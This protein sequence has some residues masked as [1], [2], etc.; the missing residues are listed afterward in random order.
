MKL[1]QKLLVAGTAIGVLSPIA[2]QASET[3][4]LEDMK[5]YERSGSKAKRFDSN[6]FINEVS[7]DI[8]KLKGRVDGLEAKQNELEA[9]SFSDTTTLDG[10]AIFSVGQADTD[11]DGFTGKIQAAYT[12]TMNLNTSFTGDD[13]LY[14]RLKTGENAPQW[15]F[16]ETYH[17]D[18]KDNSDALKV[19]KIWYCLLYTSPS[20]RDAHESRMP[21]SA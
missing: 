4:N 14:V 3:F 21:S 7:E 18:T 6:T 13:N 1:F 5:S 19:D 2:V 17:I 16:K 8:V 11:D 9:G 12:Y 20:P 15:K 10:K